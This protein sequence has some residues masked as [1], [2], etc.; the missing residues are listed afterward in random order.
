[1]SKKNKNKK[2]HPKSYI[3]LIGIIVPIIFLLA[4]IFLFFSNSPSSLANIYVS[5]ENPK[6]GDTVFIKVKT[7]AKDVA[8][9]F[10]NEKLNFYKKANSNQWI[11]FLG[12]DADQNV[13]NYKISVDTSNAE[14]LT[15]DIKVA[16]ASFSSQAVAPAPAKNQNGI[17]NEKAVDNIRKNDNPSLNKILENPTAKPYFSNPFSSPLSSM[18]IG[19]FGFGK[20][21]GFGKYKLQHLGVDLTA[22]D[23]TDIYAVNDGKVVATLNLSNYGK[24]VIIDHGLD[25]FSLYLHLDKFSVLPGEMVKR[26]QLIGLSGETGY[27]TGPHLH[28]SMRV[29]GERVDPL[30]FIQTTQDLNDNS[31]IASISNAFQNI[32]K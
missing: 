31:F 4:A 1:M 3:F 6:Q 13:G 25:I 23:K 2:R 5:S 20:F 26:G 30:A 17:S 12:I 22:P 10:N 15:K 11:S 9:N 21:L 7:S 14:H 29:D 16:L 18:K 19:G 24:T 27:T 32:F 8:G 28:F